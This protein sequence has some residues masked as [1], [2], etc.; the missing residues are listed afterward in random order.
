[1]TPQ[2]L[3]R[4]DK[5]AY[6]CAN[7]SIVDPIMQKWWRYAIEQIPLWLA[8]NA[9]TMIG[10]VI[11]VLTSVILIYNCP[12]AKE[13]APQWATGLCCLGLFIYQTLD[14]IDGKQARRTNT[15]NP[16]GEL[17]DHGCDSV[18]TVFVTIA[19]ACTTSLGHSPAFLM[20]QCF[21]APSLFYCV[22]WQTYVTGLMKFGR[23]DV[24][25]AQ[26]CIMS[27]MLVN[28]VF[29]P[30]IWDISL[31][32]GVLSFRYLPSFFAS[33]CGIYTALSIFGTISE[34]GAGKN[35]STVAGTSVIAP[36]LHIGAVMGSGV[37][38]ALNSEAEIYQQNPIVFVI[39]FGLMATKVTNKLIVAHMSKSD[40]WQ[41][42]DYIFAIPIIMILKIWYSWVPFTE[43][44]LLNVGL[45]LVV[46][47]VYC[48]SAAICVE[49]CNHMK[50]HLFKIPYQAENQ[51]ND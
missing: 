10:L 1:M 48:Y 5:H 28:T 32:G 44:F 42:F 41:T 19:S 14:A 20:T 16:L 29:G 3:K 35:G 21:V 6:N 8:P 22:H 49:I 51:H 40:I 31:L 23:F 37:Y 34:G 17:F 25:E 27:M 45:V 26:L 36:V 9:I 38:I 33:A 47:D 4:L 12:T 46:Y 11:N 30:G 39:L 24:T 18:S 7:E 2:Q 15:S 43:S 50:L 13:P